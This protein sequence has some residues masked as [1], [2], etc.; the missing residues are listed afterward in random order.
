LSAFLNAGLLYW[1]LHRR[2]VYRFGPHWWGVMG[3]YVIANIVMGV[4]LF[5]LLPASSWWLAS[6][7]VTLKVS[8]ALGLCVV[9]AASYFVA[10]FALG[11]RLKD[12]RHA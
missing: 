9:G 7:G 1:G 12:I 11:F 3:R 8:V 5:S 4:V 10:L 6:G 2:D